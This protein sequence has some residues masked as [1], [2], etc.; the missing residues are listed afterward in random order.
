VDTV[1]LPSANLQWTLSPRFEIG[2]RCGEATGDFLVS[3]RFL[4]TGGSTFTPAFDTA[5]N[6]GALRS[7]LSINVIDAD[8]ASREPSLLPWVEMRWRIGVRVA[9]LFFDSEEAS[10]LLQQHVSNWFW[11]VGPHATLE[12]WCPIHDTHAGLFCKIDGAG[13]LGRVQQGF[14]ETLGT[15][16]GFTRQAQNMPTTMLNVEAGVG[17]T[18]RETWRFSAGYIYE[19]WWDATVAAGSRGDVWMQ[20]VFVRGEWRY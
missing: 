9:G 18:P 5:G 11:G 10:P 14:E 12:L 16:S 15:A 13:V 8:Y 20:G 3:Y 6:P 2:Y 19:H 17:W 1:T 4:A 7:R